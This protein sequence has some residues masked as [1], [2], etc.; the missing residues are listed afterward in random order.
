MQLKINLITVPTSNK[1]NLILVKNN[2]DELVLEYSHILRYAE[3]VKDSFGAF[4]L[5]GYSDQE[6]KVGDLTLEPKCEFEHKRL[7]TID[8]EIELE[9]YAK[10]D[11]YSIKKVVV[12]SDLNHS[13]PRFSQAFLKRFAE[14]INEFDKIKEAYV[15]LDING[16]IDLT[17]SFIAAISKKKEFY[18]TTEIIELIENAIDKGVSFE[19]F[20]KSLT[21]K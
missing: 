18:N 7:T 4:Y 9:E 19:E 11:K 17:P 6:I 3:D 12:T 10:N 8:N 14:S 16:N 15:K 20:K 2:K 1:S 21:Q 13:L 5:Y